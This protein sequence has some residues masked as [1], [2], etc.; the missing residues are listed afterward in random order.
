MTNY[1]YYKNKLTSFPYKD[2]HIA[3]TQSYVR[4]E[5][6]K[7]IR[8]NVIYTTNCLDRECSKCSI[9]FTWWLMQEYHPITLDTLVEVRDNPYDKWCKRYFARFN[10]NGKLA[11]WCN[12]KTSKTANGIMDY[13]VWNEYRLIEKN[14]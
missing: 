2:P 8:N 4:E 1:E 12:G 10:S 5:L 7:F 3:S 11:A 9:L 6:C 13:K 14:E